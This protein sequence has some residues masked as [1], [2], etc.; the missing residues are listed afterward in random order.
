MIP[1]F[2]EEDAYNNLPKVREITEVALDVAIQLKTLTRLEI[3]VEGGVH[4]GA[5]LKLLENPHLHG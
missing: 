2:G 1:E 4:L 5:L 3:N